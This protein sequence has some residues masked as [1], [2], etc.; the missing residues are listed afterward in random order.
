MKDW[1]FD[2]I[3]DTLWDLL[4]SSSIV[5]ALKVAGAGLAFAFNVVLARLLGADGA[6]V[7]FLSLTVLTIGS[8]I[9]RLGL[10]EVFVRRVAADSDQGR[11]GRVRG[12]H[13]TG[14]ALATGLACVVAA[15][16]FF[17][18]PWIARYGF[19]NPDLTA[20]IAMMALAVVP[21]VLSRLYSQILKALKKIVA[22][23]LIQKQGILIPGLSIVGTY[24]LCG[25]LGWGVEGAIW[26]FVGSAVVATLVGVYVW[27]KAVPSGSA[28][29]EDSSAPDAEETKSVSI[30]SLTRPSIPLFW[31]E[32]LGFLRNEAGLL[33]LGV[34]ATEAEV[35]IYGTALRIAL[36]TSF[37]LVAINSIV[38]PQIASLYESGSREE[39]DRVARYAVK[40]STLLAT[41]PLLVFV[42]VP[43]F[44]LSLF[45]SEFTAGTVPLIILAI[46]QF[47]NVSTG[48]VGYLLI[49]TG[50]EK[51]MRNVDLVATSVGM[52]LYLTL[53]PSY[54]AAG[55]AVAYG[56]AI[57]VRYLGSAFIVARSLNIMLFGPLEI[58]NDVVAH[59]RAR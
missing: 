38:S 25:W 1:L 59:L 6:G 11:W 20:P 22:F 44:V 7:Y 14:M 15:V 3:D 32:T 30:G 26:A 45:G 2:R 41:P 24:L 53:I 4:R 21:L 36:L 13:R 17:S 40:I 5:F 37:I 56:T 34:W 51:Q 52:A 10:D 42:L 49:M 18:A 58:I 8:I 43:D 57:S 12:V 46:A 39:L 31:V 35:G 29:V 48:P 27:W 16:L 33:L 47:L 28:S 54:G 23:T 55:A 19:S 9:G 50:R